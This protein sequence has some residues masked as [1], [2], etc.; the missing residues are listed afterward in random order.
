[1]TD[2]EI[3]DYLKRAGVA[4]NLAHWEDGKLN[5]CITSWDELKRLCV[6]IWE[7]GV[8]EGRRDTLPENFV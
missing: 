5:T 3:L 6:T 1:M 7:D 8:D 2:E 4:N